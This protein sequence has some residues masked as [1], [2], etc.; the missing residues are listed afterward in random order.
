MNYPRTRL[1]IYLVNTLLDKETSWIFTYR[2]NTFNPLYKLLK[3][4]TI[5]NFNANTYLNKNHNNII[6]IP[7]IS[8]TISNSSYRLNK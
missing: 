1:I 7:N 2:N 6:A 3:N 4:I 5:L 8:I